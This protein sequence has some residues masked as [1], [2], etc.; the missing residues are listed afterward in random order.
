VNVPT[1]LLVVGS[2]AYLQEGLKGVLDPNNEKV[3]IQ[4]LNFE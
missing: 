1:T 2:V 3:I 4:R